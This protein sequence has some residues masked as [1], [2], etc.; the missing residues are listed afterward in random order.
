[1]GGL[2]CNTTR[3]EGKGKGNNDCRSDGKGLGAC[4]DDAMGSSGPG[5]SGASGGGRQRT[6]CDDLAGKSSHQ[7]LL[8]VPNVTIYRQD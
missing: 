2:D 6:L 8:H 5:G 1:M 4:N 7:R 3:S